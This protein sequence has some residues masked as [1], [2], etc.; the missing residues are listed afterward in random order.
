MFAN[1]V[2]AGRQLGTRLAELHEENA[3]V[4]GLPRGGV[5]VAAQVARALDAPLDIVLVRK[6]GVPHQPELGMG[7][8]GEDG[9]RVLDASL[10]RRA[11]VTNAELEAVE[12]R[13]RAELERRTRQYRGDTPPLSLTGRAVIIVDDGLATGG[14]ARAAI[15]VTRARGATRVVVAVPVAPQGTMSSVRRDAD[16]VVVLAMP[17]G[18][19]ALGDYYDD[20]RPTEDAEVVQLLRGRSDTAG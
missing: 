4:L 11:G 15:T 3:I 1:R 12:T 2:D 7:A 14:T 18:F 6:L 8:L 19:R 16:R 13:E 20:F 5:P 10:M 9:A 17:S